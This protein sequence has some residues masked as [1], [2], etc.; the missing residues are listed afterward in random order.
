MIYHMP[1]RLD[2]EFEDFDQVHLRES[3]LEFGNDEDEIN[4]NEV[5]KMKPPP[6]GLWPPPHRPRFGLLLLDPPMELLS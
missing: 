3:D 4:D 6:S 1:H 2:G 5:I